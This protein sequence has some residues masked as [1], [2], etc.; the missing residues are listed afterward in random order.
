MTR[1]ELTAK[2]LDAKRRK[3]LSWKQIA[4]AIGP[5]SPVLYT[6]ALLG[7]MTLKDEEAEKLVKLLELDEMDAIQLTEPPLR[8]SLRVVPP[9]DPLIYRFYELVQTYGTTWKALIEEEFGDGIM[10]AIDFDM[11]IKREENPKGDR[12]RISMSGKFLPYKRY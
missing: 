5:G 8:G 12:V 4:E 6:A 10:S 7:Q 11:E 2:I 3:R 1:E 9:T